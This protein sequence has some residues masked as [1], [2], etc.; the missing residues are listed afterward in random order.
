MLP[1]KGTAGWWVVAVDA[2]CE[3]VFKGSG[4]FAVAP[5]ADTLRLKVAAATEPIAMAR[6]TPLRTPLGHPSDRERCLD[7]AN[8]A[9][10]IVM[11]D[12]DPPGQSPAGAF[13]SRR[14]YALRALAVDSPSA[15]FNGSMSTIVR[16][17]VR[18][19]AYFRR[20]IWS[21]PRS[22]VPRQNSSMD[23]CSESSE[24]QQNGLVQRLAGCRTRTLRTACPARRTR[25][26]S[27]HA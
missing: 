4:C 13:D 2:G 25:E 6:S 16:W 12:R 27:S 5:H 8:R 18:Q 14:L 10:S 21:T 22:Q 1:V 11:R 23:G 7:K 9:S 26:R 17:S 20:A 19:Y 15:K 24:A 3:L